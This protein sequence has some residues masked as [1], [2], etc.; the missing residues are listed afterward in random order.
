EALRF[1]V[2]NG[3][4]GV[5]RPR[6][7]AIDAVGDRLRLPCVGAVDARIGVGGN[8]RWLFAV[9]ETRR[10]VPVD[11]GASRTDTLPV[12]ADHAAD[13]GDRNRELSPVNEIGADRVAP[14]GVAEV[15]ELPRLIEEVVLALIVDE[16]IGIVR[17]IGS[18][19][20]V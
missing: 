10:V 8:Q 14:F 9:A 19:T 3:V 2:E 7:S 20:E 17:E 16:A 1:D 15:G 6:S 11:D 4:A 5:L 18:W 13:L 12:S